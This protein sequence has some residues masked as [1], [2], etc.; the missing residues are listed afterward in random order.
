[1]LAVVA[2]VHHDGPRLSGERL[3]DQDILDVVERGLSDPG[4]DPHP[5][6]NRLACDPEPTG[7]LSDA[8]ARGLQ[9]RPVRRLRSGRKARREARLGCTLT[10][11]TSP[12]LRWP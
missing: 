4:L 11:G 9:G 12:T 3:R 6:V 5:T 10:R 1:M 7:S 8:A 2:E